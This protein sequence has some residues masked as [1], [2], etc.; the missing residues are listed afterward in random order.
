MTYIRVITLNLKKKTK[1]FWKKS[2]SIFFYLFISFYYD[3]LKTIYNYN[4]KIY[5]KS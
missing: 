1:K 3:C 5:F 4:F 2:N